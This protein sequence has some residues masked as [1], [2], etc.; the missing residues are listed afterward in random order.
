MAKAIA[1]GGVFLSFKGDKNELF[2][3]YAKIYA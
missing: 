2:G 3:W 1:I